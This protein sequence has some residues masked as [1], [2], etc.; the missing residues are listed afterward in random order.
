MNYRLV[1]S[2]ED[3]EVVHRIL[4]KFS[5][6]AKFPITLD[7]LLQRWGNFAT[8]VEQGYS[9]THYDYLNDLSTRDLLEALMLQVPT[10]TQG[11]LH[12]I[13][14]PIDT[15]FIRA[16]RS[17]EKPVSGEERHRSLFWW[18]RVPKKLTEELKIELLR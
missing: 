16:T 13:V 4:A 7:F 6:Q 18:Y 14:H 1:L 9:D 17:I 10:S 2:E 3:V 5:D 11:N 8:E 12:V 15:R